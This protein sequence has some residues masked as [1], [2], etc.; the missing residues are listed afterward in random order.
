MRPST[1]LFFLCISFPFA[2]AAN[3]GCS[4]SDHTC[5]IQ[6]METEAQ[7]ITEG[8]W[9]NQAFRDIA[10]S[11]AMEGDYDGAASLVGR[12]DNPDTQA[13]TIRAIGMAVA[14]HR[15]LDDQMYKSIFA[16]LS[17]ESAKIKDAGAKDIGYTYIAM[18]QA[19]AGLDDD[20]T[21]TTQAMTNPALKHKAYGETAEIQAERGDYTRAMASI[22]AI[23]SDAFRNKALEIVSGIFV[24]RAEY[25]HALNTAEKIT[26]AQRKVS[27]IQT[28]LNAQQ[29]LDSK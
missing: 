15:D 13:M 6:E 27:A 23:D 21:L 14:L 18:A 1:I 7:S 22:A 20:A 8:R 17:V 19:F 9:R 24:K 25:D 26:N 3:E 29:G 4:A 5:L 28:I 11:K 16:K 2:V 10:V 12:I